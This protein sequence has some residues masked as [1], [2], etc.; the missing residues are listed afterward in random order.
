[1]TA[2]SAWCG[3]DQGLSRKKLYLSILRTFVWH[4]YPDLQ[5]DQNFQ[6]N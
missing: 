3:A 6:N 1:M 5:L 4:S 2:A